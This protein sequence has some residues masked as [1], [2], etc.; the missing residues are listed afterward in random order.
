M[1]RI[2]VI[3]TAFIGD[4]ILTLPLIQKLNE[5]FSEPVIDVVSIPDTAEIFNAS[6]F[7]NKNWVYDK[8]SKDKSILSVLKLAKKLRN[9]NYTRLFAPHR[10]FRTALITL[11][12]GIK[13]TTSFDRSS[14]GFIYKNRIRYE[15]NFHEVRR[16][17]S[18][19]GDKFTAGDSWKIKPE[20]KSC[21]LPD[22]AKDITASSERI[23]AVAPG[24]V[25]GTKIYPHGYFSEIIKS[26]S[27][28]NYRAVLIGGN[29]DL[30]LC[31][32]IIHE[33]GEAALNLAGELNLIESI[34]FLRKC[35]FLVC[36]DSAPTHMA[37]AA[38]IPAITLYVSTV[39][40]FGFYPYLH[41]SK[42]LSYD[43]LECKPCGIHGHDECPLGVFDCAH[44][45]PPERILKIIE[46]NFHN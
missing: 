43:N 42:Y 7:V 17:L 15:K 24:S 44:N 21:S 12:S 33:S 23:Y 32:R 1:E 26:L 36:N 39:P 29:N 27:K 14:F 9:E 18:L 4:A 46:Q 6:P 34:E 30:A 3:Q 8:K 41:N 22:I 40:D 5:V 28:M 2:L 37:M 13:N 16:N 20:V 45:L 38:G 25:W 31:E 10:S 11:L 35:S 19:L